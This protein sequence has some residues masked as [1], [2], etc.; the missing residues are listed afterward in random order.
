MSAE[1]K[2]LWRWLGHGAMSAKWKCCGGGW[3]M[4]N[5]CGVDIVVVGGGSMG[6][7]WRSGYCCGGGGARF[8][9][10]AEWNVVVVEH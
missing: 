1:W 4:G 3:S 10:C 5:E 9:L 7:D 8:N 6:N 2:L